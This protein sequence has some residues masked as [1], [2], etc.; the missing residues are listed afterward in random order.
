MYNIIR[1]M[2]ESTFRWHRAKHMQ[3]S[4]SASNKMGM[5]FTF[6]LRLD[7]E[8]DGYRFLDVILYGAANYVGVYARLRWE[9][10][11]ES[12]LGYNEETEEEFLKGDYTEGSTKWYRLYY[13]DSC[14]PDG[15]NKLLRGIAKRANIIE[16]R[17]H[18]YEIKEVPEELRDIETH[19]NVED[20]LEAEFHFEGSPKIKE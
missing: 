17:E 1:Q 13:H 6:R 5:H 18:W 8:E 14:W 15:V 3:G 20:M 2:I 11:H 16:V 10:V 4:M 9:V 7:S 19:D 12:Q